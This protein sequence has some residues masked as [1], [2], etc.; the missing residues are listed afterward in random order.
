[1]NYYIRALEMVDGAY[2]LT[3]QKIDVYSKNE[4]KK[5]ICY[6][7]HKRPW[8]LNYGHVKV[9]D[10]NGNQLDSEQIVPLPLNYF[11]EKLND[12][13]YIALVERNVFINEL[14]HLYPEEESLKNRA[15]LPELIGEGRLY[16]NFLVSDDGKM[17]NTNYVNILLSSY[18]TPSLD[19][20]F[21]RL[22][23]PDYLN[24]EGR[25]FYNTE[26]NVFIKRL[27]QRTDLKEVHKRLIK[28]Y[29]SK[30]TT[31]ANHND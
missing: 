23:D 18:T 5:E 11:L 25:F 7:N 31:D 15:P 20:L 27:E 16:H 3:K 9:S 6:I 21:K 22:E 10:D 29:K 13:E 8:G 19:E 17:Y 1:M 2:E 30:L 28:M 26:R 12:P 14:A 24:Y 4:E